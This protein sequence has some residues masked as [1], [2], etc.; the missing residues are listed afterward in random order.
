MMMTQHSDRTPEK[1]RYLSWCPNKHTQKST[2]RK[3]TLYTKRDKQIERQTD[4]QSRS[5]KVK[6]KVK[7]TDKQVNKRNITTKSLRSILSISAT[8]VAKTPLMYS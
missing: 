1:Q 6:R 8:V 5:Q 3:F 2:N 4:R 7:E